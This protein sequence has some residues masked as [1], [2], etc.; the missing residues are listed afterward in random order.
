MTTLDARLTP[1]EWWNN[2]PTMG[3]GQEMSDPNNV[4]LSG[5]VLN[6]YARMDN[7]F[8]TG[9]TG[10]L[11]QTSGVQGDS[12]IPT[13]SFLYG[14]AQATIKVPAGQG[15]WPAFWL[16]PESHN[17]ANGE[18]DILEMLGNDTTTAY[19]TVHRDGVFEQH[20]VHTIDLSQGFHT[21]GVDWEPG[22]ET[23][24][25]DGQ[26]TAVLSNTALIS[27]EPARLILDL[28][29]GGPWAGAP[30]ASTPSPADMQVLDIQVWQ[31]PMAPSTTTIADNGPSPSITTQSGNLAVSAGTL[32]SGP[33][34]VGAAA[35]MNLIAT[36]VPASNGTQR[37]VS[38]MGQTDRV[39][40]SIANGDYTINSSVV[41]AAA[42]GA[43][44]TNSRRPDTF[45]RIYGDMSASEVI[46]ASDNAY[47]NQALSANFP[48]DGFLLNI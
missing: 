42:E 10:S 31:H 2:G 40:S 22:S 5:G 1:H 45:Y 23:F 24:Y 17:D 30:N 8:G 29:V 19:Q 35:P 20:T 36:A 16:L 21:Y 26:E 4:V 7:S 27:N 48:G 37:V 46:T 6:L 28:A 41:I 9:W 32:T 47:F 12:S 13:F 14:Y 15:L 39:L 44:A 18:L 33:Q 38:L 34:S 3:E 11:V 25:I 43:T